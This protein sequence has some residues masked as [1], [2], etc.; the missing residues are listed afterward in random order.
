M[1]SRR[2]RKLGG[3]VGKHRNEFAVGLLTSVIGGAILA[4]ATGVFDGSE[5]RGS[6]A[7]QQARAASDL[8]CLLPGEA[9]RRAV[10]QGRLDVAKVGATGE[11]GD[12]VSV[13]PGDVVQFQLW[14]FN[15]ELEDDVIDLRARFQP[16]EQPAVMI[17]VE[18]QACGSN[19]H[20]LREAATVESDGRPIRL[21]FRTGSVYVR[22]YIDGRYTTRGGSD[23]LFRSEDGE[24]LGRLEAHRDPTRPHITVTAK[25]RVKDADQ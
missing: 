15:R 1:G 14:L 3:W 23:V 21:A 16:G 2:L 7:A 12:S 13:V 8:G 5:T 6:S 9:G 24:S 19:T 20:L 11:Y 17:P 18:A 10:I 4:V 22:S 25:A